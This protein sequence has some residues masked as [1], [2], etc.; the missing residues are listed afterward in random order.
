[1]AKNAGVE[2]HT[3]VARLEKLG[4]LKQRGVLKQDT[5][6]EQTEKLNK[7]LEE[8]QKTLLTEQMSKAPS[9][10]EEDTDTA[11][12]RLKQLGELKERGIVTDEAFN[13]MLHILNQKLAMLSKEELGASSP[14]GEEPEGEREPEIHG[15]LNNEPVPER[16]AF[17]DPQTSHLKF[18]GPGPKKETSGLAAKP[19]RS[20]GQAARSQISRGPGSVRGIRLDTQE[21]NNISSKHDQMVAES[22]GNLWETLLSNGFSKQVFDKLD[23]HGIESLADAADPE[24]CDD[25]L[26]AQA[27]VDGEEAARFRK[28]MASNGTLL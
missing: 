20:G 25:A 2:Y 13:K 28:I 7:Q 14:F 16:A 3:I 6:E 10:S 15:V 27:G 18:R 21:I 12:A 17:A 24:L 26:L 22:K 9:S 5:F 8:V 11:L 1:M 19:E 23:A 4:N